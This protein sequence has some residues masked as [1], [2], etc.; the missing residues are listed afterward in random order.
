MIRGLSHTNIR[1]RDID[2]CLPFYVNVLGLK[3]SFDEDTRSSGDSE[4]QRRAVFLR[5][6]NGPARSFVVL[7]T[8]PAEAGQEDSEPGGYLAR[9]SA[10]GVNHFG[11]WA[12]DLGAILTRAAAA[13]VPAV[14]DG[15]VD[16]TGR[17][18]GY[19]DVRDEICLR[20]AQLVDPENNVIQL[21][22]WV[23]PSG[24]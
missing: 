7:Q 2:K 12:D 14:R 16:C 8:L 9:L 15:P 3:V 1:V 13:N 6:E 23:G 21:D 10:M 22:E 20:T 5:W 17:N 11:F 19:A 24:V 18:V 4:F